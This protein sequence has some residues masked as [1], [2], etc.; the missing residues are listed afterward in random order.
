VENQMEI[1]NGLK[2]AGGENVVNFPGGKTGFVGI[3]HEKKT[4]I[5]NEL[6]RQEFNAQTGESTEIVGALNA[7]AGELTAATGTS[8]WANTGATGPLA[9]QGPN[10]GGNQRAA[11]IVCWGV[12]CSG[13]GKNDNMEYEKGLDGKGE[14]QM[15]QPQNQNSLKIWKR[16]VCSE[17]EETRPASST[18]TLL[19]K[20]K[21]ETEISTSDEQRHLK[22]RKWEDYL[23]EEVES[24]NEMA[25]ATE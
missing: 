16:V 3:K 23:E 7:S 22:I 12:F 4:I 17:E 11:E 20:R 19:G 8:K 5:A 10:S 14:V 25:E 24:E 13:L 18:I 9:M 1:S 2:L 21:G 6:V 15:G